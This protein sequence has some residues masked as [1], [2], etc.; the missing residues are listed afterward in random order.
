[1]FADDCFVWL[2][3]LI[4]FT[5]MPMPFCRFHQEAC[6]SMVVCGRPEAVADDVC[7]SP[8]I[9]A[10]LRRRIDRDGAVEAQGACCVASRLA[11]AIPVPVRSATVERPVLG[12]PLTVDADRMLSERRGGCW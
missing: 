6:G 8:S 10:R 2:I 11:S 4:A 9:R 12:V 5:F 3:L 1:M 7:L